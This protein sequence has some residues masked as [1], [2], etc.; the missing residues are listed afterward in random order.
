MGGAC[1]CSTHLS[2]LCF[3]SPAPCGVL[4]SVNP[5]HMYKQMSICLEWSR[6][7]NSVPAFQRVSAVQRCDQSSCG[8]PR[9]LR[10]KTFVPRLTNKCFFTHWMLGRDVRPNVLNSLL[11]I[12]HRFGFAAWV[13]WK[14]IRHKDCPNLVC[15][16]LYAPKF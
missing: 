12:G 2:F 3:V 4:L 16:V 8:E 1:A 6:S 10:Q 7:T 11:H 15:L 14:S 13:H 5:S 9:M